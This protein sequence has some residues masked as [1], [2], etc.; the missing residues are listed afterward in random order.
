MQ[1]LRTWNAQLTPS[2]KLKLLGISAI[3]AVSIYA[4][5]TN[6]NKQKTFIDEDD[7][8]QSDQ[9][10]RPK[11]RLFMPISPSIAFWGSYLLTTC[12]WALTFYKPF[13]S[14][15][16]KYIPRIMS[17]RFV[18]S[19]KELLPPIPNTLSEAYKLGH[20]QHK[21]THIES[22]NGDTT[23]I[24]NQASSIIGRNV[25]SKQLHD[26]LNQILLIENKKS[27]ISKV[28]GIFSFINILWFL[29][30]LG[31]STTILPVIYNLGQPIWDEIYNFIIIRFGGFLKRL[32][33]NTYAYSVYELFGYFICWYFMYLGSENTKTPIG[34]WVALTGLGLWMPMQY[35]SIERW[36]TQISNKIVT[37][38]ISILSSV[39]SIPLAYKYNSKLLGLTSV[40]GLYSYLGFFFQHFFGGYIIG[41][42]GDEAVGRSCIAS[43][44]FNGGLIGAR[45]MNVN[46]HPIRMFI[47]PILVVSNIVYFL[48]MLIHTNEY[49]YWW[50]T[51]RAQKYWKRQ[52]KMIV[53]LL[54]AMFFGNY[55][56]YN[57]LSNTAYVY[58]GL[59]ILQKCSEWPRLWEGHYIYYTVFGISVSCWRIALYLHKNPQIITGMFKFD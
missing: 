32:L 49:R 52:I 26:I 46:L 38:M 17:Y 35:I 40:I 31:I 8:I 55:L 2:S 6:S 25:T 23:N 4:L 18:P 59:Y 30:I 3:T 42:D 28:F 58:T 7:E 45:L 29:S 20:L 14:L 13:I 15:T 48:A 36:D 10:Q 11:F 5:Y 51:N 21:L 19:I 56:G 44:I 9:Q 16:N 33:M 27:M 24:L 22:I 39:I 53:S 50:I 12:T 34:F 54:M 47:T 37:S 43:M 41:F 57:A 1:V